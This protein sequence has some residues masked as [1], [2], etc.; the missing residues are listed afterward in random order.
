MPKNDTRIAAEHAL[1]ISE[2]GLNRVIKVDTEIYHHKWALT[3]EEWDSRSEFE[4]ILR[5]T[6]LALQ[7]WCWCTRSFFF[8][9]YLCFLPV[10]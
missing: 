5:I 2:A 7:G 10:L 8:V 6:Q 3:K 9:R 4:G 1:L